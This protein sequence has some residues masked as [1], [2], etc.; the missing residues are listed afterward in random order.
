MAAR[1][2]A[3]NP[4]RPTPAIP[5][6][7]PI[8]VS[9]SAGMGGDR[10]P[11]TGMDGW[12]PYGLIVCPTFTFTFSGGRPREGPASGGGGIIGLVDA[13]TTSDSG[14]ADVDAR[15]R[16]GAVLAYGR[17]ICPGG[18]ANGAGLD[19]VGWRTP[20]GGERMLAADGARTG[21]ACMCGGAVAGG[22]TG[23]GESMRCGCAW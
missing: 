3:A 13:Y 21:I 17:F 22:E 4:L 12:F 10:I 20:G 8:F 15:G 7:P 16:S 18:G 14:C 9:I 2:A 23:A 11:P 1:A 6:S 5:A 19:C